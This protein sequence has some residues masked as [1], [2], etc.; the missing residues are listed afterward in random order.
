MP[1]AVRLAADLWVPEGG[2]PV[3]WWGD[4]TP[5]QQP[6]DD[7]SLVYDSAPHQ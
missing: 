6:M 7:A 1:D 5:D 4:L 2:G 3:M